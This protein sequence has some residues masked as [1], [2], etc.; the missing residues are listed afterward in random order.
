MLAHSSVSSLLQTSSLVPSFTTTTYTFAAQ[1]VSTIPKNSILRVYVPAEVTV[2]SS[3]ACSGDGS[4]LPGSLTCTYD[5]GLGYFTITDGF[6]SL[7]SYPP[8]DF[9][10][11]I[12]NL[13]NPSTAV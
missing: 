8:R 3:P 13:Q 4:G 2:G 12:T 10:L 5:S 6:P 11:E 7:T 9:T 1:T